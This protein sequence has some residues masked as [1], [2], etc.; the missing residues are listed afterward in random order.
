MDIGS[1]ALD[2]RSTIKLLRRLRGLE[3]VE[4]VM[5]PGAHQ[6]LREYWAVYKFRGNYR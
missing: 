5:N 6:S 4:Q 1:C 3:M 2:Y